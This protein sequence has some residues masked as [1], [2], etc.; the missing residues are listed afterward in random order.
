MR[1]RATSSALLPA[2]CLALLALAVPGV[3]RA[4]SADLYRA[5]LRS[6][7]LGYYREALI[8]FE[9][10][11]QVQPRADR[12]V[13]E[14]G[15]WRTPYLPYYQQGR[16][17]FRLGHY[18]AA[19]EALEKSER[20]GSIAGHRAK[21]HYRRL[22][23]LREEIRERIDREVENLYRGATADYETVDEL[24][25]S[26]LIGPA[27]VESEVPAF[28]DIGA[29]LRKTTAHLEDASLFA[30]A[31]ELQNAMSLIDQ[32]RDGIAEM[33]V[34]IEIRE[35]ELRDQ[36][37][38]ELLAQRREAARQSYRRAERLVTE[39][40]CDDSA[41][42]LLESLDRASL[43]APD[44][45]GEEGFEPDLLLADAHLLCDHLALAGI[46]FQRA[47]AGASPSPRRLRVQ[48]LLRERRR[49]GVTA[50]GKQLPSEPDGAE[51]DGARPDGAEPDGA[52]PDDAEQ[53]ATRDG[54]SRLRREQALSDYLEASAH[55]GLDDCRDEEIARLIG[56]AREALGPADGTADPKDAAAVPV[57]FRPHLVL[58]RA[59]ARCYDRDGVERLLRLADGHGEATAAELDELERWLARHPKLEPYSGSFAL[60]VGAYD[61][62]H[63]VGWP[64]L[65]QPGEDIREVR[66][67][68]DRHGFEVEMLEN[69]TGDELEQALDRF[70]LEHGGEAGHRLVF[71]YAGHG[72]TEITLH[73]VKLG[74]L[75]PVDAGDPRGDRGFLRDLFG[76][77]RFREYA[78]RSNANDLLF[79]FDSCFAGTVFEATRACLPPDCLPPGGHGADLAELIARPVRMFMTAGD[80]EERVPDQSL[81]RQMITRAL[82]G[83]ADRDADG[84]ILGSELGTFVQSEV[85]ARQREGAT[86]YKTASLGGRQLAEPKWGTLMEGSFGRG[87]LLFH[88]PQDTLVQRA[89]A[90]GGGPRAAAVDTELVYWA[91]ARASG[92]PEDYRR[93]LDRYPEGHFAQLG[94]WI[95]ERLAAPSS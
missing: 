58:A 41:I 18:A 29:S 83:D 91:A 82:S 44:R 55:A 22:L 33:A 80:E 8:Y 95:L 66:A 74:Y 16:A 84:F 23:A 15:M 62:S 47:P 63:A 9:A 60:L 59:S 43:D 73:G 27:D 53:D 46:Y 28:E 89:R 57:A 48:E 2:L 3:A 86:R 31:S 12:T 56:R 69:P 67:V 50:P 42:A 51:P 79:M 87:D 45:P 13:R 94:R 71:Y 30:A 24:R 26:P 14:Y 10:A 78:I 20:Q 1:P 17:L 32:A 11:A 5:G 65:Y 90:R 61:Y 77:E 37:E 93:Y 40:G 85:V 52:R 35:R 70:Y 4:D 21:R 72:H 92:Q 6:F 38:R 76:M 64:S 34:A 19:L 25:R 81:F 54:A 39:S 7:E 49:A 36:R 68:L 88:V 75:V